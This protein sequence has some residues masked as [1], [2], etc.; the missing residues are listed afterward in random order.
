MILDYV[1][2]TPARNEAAFIERTIQSVLAQTV[3]PRRWIIVSD[4][5]TDSTDAIVERY[6]NVGWLELVRLPVDGDRNF[7]AKVRAFDAGLA[8]LQDVAY[9]V[10]VNLDADVSFPPDYFA[11]LL[12][13]FAADPRLGV[14]GTHYTEGNFHSFRDSFINPAHVNGQCQLF[15]R[16]CFEDIGGYVPIEGG[17]IDWVAVTTARMRGWTTRSFDERVFEHHRKMG[18]AGGSE[19]SARY[20]YGKKD[21]ALGGHPLWQLLRGSFQMTK[22]PYVIGG[23]LLLAGYF[24]CWLTGAKR[25]VST[26]LMAFHRR[27]QLQR[28]RELVGR[29]STKRGTRLQGSAISGV[30][31]A[32][33]D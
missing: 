29:W 28:M 30:R 23:A 4:G 24:G 5:S 15:R 27:E 10:I 18:T 22:R 8:R 26:E 31:G 3:L 13:K 21:F 6:L 33:L 32:D 14:A 12:D 2:V 9:D 7:A 25:A 17:G 20:N 11:F 1:L 19:L 16:E